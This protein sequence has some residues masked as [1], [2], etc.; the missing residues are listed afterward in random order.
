MRRFGLVLLV[1]LLAG[2]SGHSR[3]SVSSGGGGAP[4][5]GSSVRTSVVGLHVHS[6]TLAALVL[7]GV[8]VN[9]VIEEA[10]DPRP[11]PGLSPFSD[12]AG[13]P[14]APGLAP[15]RRVN[16]QDCSQPPQDPFA[17]LRCR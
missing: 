14:P 3:L 13:T 5:S 12:W 6:D 1:A 15:H 11:F 10:R 4:A 7:A 17:N 16:E 9:A 2:C 8:L